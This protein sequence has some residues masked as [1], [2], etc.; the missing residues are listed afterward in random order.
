[1]SHLMDNT[2]ATIGEKIKGNVEELVGRITNDPERIEA[3]QQLK[4]GTH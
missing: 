4:F 2:K 3:G 1:M